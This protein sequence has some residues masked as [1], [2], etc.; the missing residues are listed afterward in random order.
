MNPTP[1]LFLLAAGGI[2]SGLLVFALAAASEKE[3]H[4]MHEM[5]ISSAATH[6]GHSA[7]IEDIRARELQRLMR[8]DSDEDGKV[9]IDEYSER[10]RHAAVMPDFKAVEVEVEDIVELSEDLAGHVRI[11]KKTGGA[12]IA[13]QKPLGICGGPFAADFPSIKG[14]W[15]P[16]D[17]SIDWFEIADAN[18]DGVLDKEEVEGAP[19]QMRARQARRGFERLDLNKDGALDEADIDL[20]LRKLEALDEDGDGTISQAEMFDLMRLLAPRG[21]D[22]RMPMRRIKKIEREHDRR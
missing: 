10:K 4:E 18:G 15:S 21:K 17:G 16:R 19:A 7:A 5:V 22:V 8:L 2:V 1:K 20:S 3:H 14:G 12:P 13:L 6:L 9:T 11:I